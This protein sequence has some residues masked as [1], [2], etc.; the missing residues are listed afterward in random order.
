MEVS[1]QQVG[2]QTKFLMCQP[3]HYGI[4][5]SI[6]AW[7][8]VSKTADRN[9]VVEQWTSLQ[10]KIK[11]LGAITLMVKP[12]KGLPDMVF[13]ANAALN[14][15]DNLVILSTFAHPERQ[16]EQEW[17][18]QWFIDAGYK[19]FVPKEEFEGAGDALFL[20]D[21][22]VG[23]YGFRTD[24]EFY[25]EYVDYAKLVRLVD[26]HF[27][28]L[29]TCFCPLD[30]VDYMIWPGAFDSESLETIRSLG[31]NEIAV[32]EAEAKQF[33]CN[34]VR[35]DRNV[36]LPSGCPKTMALLEE[37][38]YVCH[39]L[40]MSEFIKSGGACKCLTLQL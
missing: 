19:V 40:A 37:H 11:E 21:H 14:L 20:G 22:L 23:A 38:N 13:T 12:R 31:G 35:I 33:A 39:P 28:H 32:P 26:P 9:K 2:E 36:I 6:N 5:Y 8:D 3:T 4:Y 24:R 7:M 17:F 34:A 27:Y 25:N 30:G 29:D 15:G 16:G 18:A 10:D 1:A